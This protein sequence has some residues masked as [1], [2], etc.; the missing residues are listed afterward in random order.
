MRSLSGLPLE[1]A[2]LLFRLFGHLLGRA[3]K[4]LAGTTTCIAAGA[5]RTAG[6]VSGTWVAA[7]ALG[8]AGPVGG[9]HVAAG[10][11]RPAGWVSRTS[12]AA[13][14]FAPTGFVGGIGATLP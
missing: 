9:T 1:L 3:S 13:G 12:V 11:L 7:G 2:R 6:F 10:T 8:A 4:R 5:L 14:A